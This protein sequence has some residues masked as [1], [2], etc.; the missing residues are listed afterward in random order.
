[1]SKATGIPVSPHE[2]VDLEDIAALADGRLVGAERQRVVQRLAADEASY[3]V[4]KEV[5]RFQEEQ[6]EAVAAAE[7]GDE[8][9][10]SGILVSIE[11]RR[12]AW[13]RWAPVGLA[14]AAMLVLAVALPR[15]IGVPSD[16][17]ALTA[18]SLEDEAVFA[19]LTNA[20]YRAVRNS[21]RGA[22]SARS[23]RLEFQ[24]GV[25][26]V[27][28]HIALRTQDVEQARGIALRLSSL[29]AN[30][31]LQ[32]LAIDGAG[33]LAQDLAARLEE[34]EVGVALDESTRALEEKLAA[35]SF[36][37]FFDFGRWVEAG[38]LA[39][40]ARNTDFFDSRASHRMLRR[41]EQSGPGDSGPKEYAADLRREIERAPRDLA[42][43]DRVLVEIARRQGARL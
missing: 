30:P 1:M 18:A 26:I 9:Q 36:D 39:A 22:T 37:L 8:D 31:E 28:L 16:A 13:Q 7:V 5:L 4:F 17:R 32:Y 20:W 10:Q 14:A 2:S 19:R 42:K 23:E 27:G 43:L 40:A 25:E 11:R 21:L 3:E 34:G 33:A 41:L 38:R 35:G 12:A 24:L 6:A 15:W 29:L